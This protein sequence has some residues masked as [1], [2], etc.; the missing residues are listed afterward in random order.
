VAA[1]ATW[2]AKAEP[3]VRAAVYFPVA[4]GCPFFMDMYKLDSL[5]L[6]INM[7]LGVNYA[8]GDK[9]TASVFLQRRSTIVSGINAAAIIQ[10]RQ[11]PQEG[12]LVH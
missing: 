10:S 7:N 4:V 11:L 3:V 9:K 6:N 1:T 12:T 2:F 8:V 5:F